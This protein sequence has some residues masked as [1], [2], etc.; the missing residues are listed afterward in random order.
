MAFKKK[1]NS[2]GQSI[3]KTRSFVLNPN[4]A[5]IKNFKWYWQFNNL[6]RPELQNRFEAAQ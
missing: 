5:N 2:F 4:F 6:K 3:R 1:I